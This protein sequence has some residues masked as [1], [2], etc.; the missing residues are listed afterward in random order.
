MDIDLTVYI[1]A[2]DK[3]DGLYHNHNAFREEARLAA[4]TCKEWGVKHKIL[5]L[6]QDRI[7]D[8]DRRWLNKARFLGQIETDEYQDIFYVNRQRLMVAK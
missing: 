2:Y 1:C 6:Q 3:S 8:Y 7:Y 4:Q 5:V